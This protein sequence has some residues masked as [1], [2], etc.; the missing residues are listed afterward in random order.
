MKSDALCSPEMILSPLSM[1]LQG[2]NAQAR[3]PLLW[4]EASVTTGS[5]WWWSWEKYLSL[6]LRLLSDAWPRVQGWGGADT[7]DD[8]WLLACWIACCLSNTGTH[9]VH[10]LIYWARGEGGFCDI[11][12][13]GITKEK[14]P[15]NV[16]RCLWK[17]VSYGKDV[18]W[19]H[20]F[21]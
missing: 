8:P 11:F 16:S 13:V 7:A 3:P 14:F 15:P 18:A 17:L 2:G 1:R 19:R 9:R 20:G 6:S 21:R 4:W 5:R 12:H 10:Y